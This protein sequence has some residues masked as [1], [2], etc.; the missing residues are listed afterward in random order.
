MWCEGESIFAEAGASGKSVL[1]C[2]LKNS[3]SGAE[4]LS[5]TPATAGGAVFMNAGCFG[6]DTADI[7]K[8]MWATDGENEIEFKREDLEFGYR[9]SPFQTN[10]LIVTKAEFGL[11]KCNEGFI[12]NLSKELMV[13]KRC[14]PA[15]GIFP[16]AGSVFKRTQGGYAGQLIDIA[17]LKGLQVGAAH[18]YHQNTPALSSTKP[19]QPQPMS[20]RS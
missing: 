6:S 12:I 17:G 19:M 2:A 4:F 18:K 15:V 13:I 20:L 7:R 3:L 1:D 16:S 10:G 9:K 5:T 14:N 11:T 8:R